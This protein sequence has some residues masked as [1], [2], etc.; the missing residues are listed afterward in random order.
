MTISRRPSRAT[1]GIDPM[2]PITIPSA[3]GVIPTPVRSGDQCSTP[4]TYAA[5]WERVAGEMQLPDPDEDGDWRARLTRLLPSR[6]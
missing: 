3:I 6:P 2:A 5:V 1:N 4:W